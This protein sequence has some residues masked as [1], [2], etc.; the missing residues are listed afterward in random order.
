MLRR[1]YNEIVDGEKLR[2]DM[3]KRQ[4]IP[5]ESDKR[6]NRLLATIVSI[7]LVFV[8]F[9]SYVTIDGNSMYPTFNPKGD[10]VFALRWGGE[11]TYGDVVII[12][13][14]DDGL[15]ATH[16]RLIKRVVAK[17]GDTVS[18]WPDDTG[19][20]VLRVNGKIV[21]EDY[22]T[23]LYVDGE[24]RTDRYFRVHTVREGC[25]FVLGDNR[26][27][28]A[29]SRTFGPQNTLRDVEIERIKG[30]AFFAIGSGGIRFL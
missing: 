8:I 17:A 5:T 7:V 16:D 4:G 19:R 9:V 22:I 11:P 15:N 10:A 24:T 2:D 27:S 1:N 6:F 13:N 23:P 25:V 18:Y 30:I 12:D 21:E 3:L 20:A 29:D 28:S 14:S 26:P